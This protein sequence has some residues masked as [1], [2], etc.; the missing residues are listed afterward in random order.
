MSQIARNLPLVVFLAILALR[1]WDPLVA[2][3]MRLVVFDTYQRIKPRAY[4]PK[5]PVKIVDV[6]KVSRTRFGPWPWPR[7]VIA[8]LVA[9]LSKAGAAAIVFDI[10][11]SDPDRTSPEEAVRYWPDTDAVRSFRNS[12]AGL[13]SHD[14]KLA[15][16]M[17]GTPV[18]TGFLLTQD[19]AAPAGVPADKA[20]F[21]FGG[22]DPRTF[23]PRYRNAIVNLPIIAAAS[24]GNGALNSIYDLDRV[25]RR[26]PLVLRLNDKLYPSI[27]AETL[28]VAQRARN[29]VIKASGASGVES[30]GEPTGLET[31]RIGHYRIPT[32]SL[33]RVW[34][35]FTKH[36][37]ERFIPAWKVLADDFDP[38]LVAG[39]IVFIWSSAPGLFDLRSTPIEPAIPNV[40]IKAQVI[41]QIIAGDYLHRPGWADA[42][43]L[44]SMFLIGLLLIVLLRHLGALTSLVVGLGGI[45]FVLGGSWIAFDRYSWLLDP[46]L[47]TVMV[48]FV[49]MTALAVSYIRSETERIRA[50]ASEH[51]HRRQTQLVNLLRRSAASANQ[52]EQ[53]EDALQGCLD[54][55][56]T[57]TAWPVGHVYEV[58]A[59]SA[60]VLLPTGIWHLDDPPRFAA[61]RALT[62]RT[63]VKRGIDLPGRVLQ[64]G[65]P[66]W[67]ADLGSHAN[68]PRAGPAEDAGIRAALGVPV[69]AGSEIAAVLEFFA[70][71]AAEPDAS[72]LSAIDNIGTQVGR[73]I[74]RKRAQDLIVR[75][76]AMITESIGYASNIQRSALPDKQLLAEALG[77]TFVIWE[78]RDV[79]GGDIYWARRIEDG[80][81]VAVADC[82]GHGV[83]GAFMTMI[84][85]GALMQA[86][87]EYPDGDPAKIIA[88]MHGF[89][90]NSLRQGD[91]AGDSDDG[92]D[93]GICRIDADATSMTYAGA[94]FP[95]LMI[96][97]GTAQE[98]KGDRF[99]I[100]YRQTEPAPRFTNHR[101]DLV[102]GMAFYLL[103]DGFVDQVGG[104]RRRAFGRRR[105]LRHL[106]DLQGWSLEE[107]RRSLLAAL[108]D[109]QGDEVRRD[110]VTVLAFKPRG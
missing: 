76:H 29:I 45:A 75:A 30:F 57:Y 7:S 81:L 2:Q 21:A 12:L 79:V 38:A 10:V 4:D 39:Q 105:L 35:R 18:V 13:P 60:D 94:R 109:Y 27:L 16:A 90:Q 5:S 51:A 59:K 72:L 46:I 1:V 106:L 11:F 107:Q 68:L 49:F 110:D 87:N 43:E 36:A 31:V 103:T 64:T 77:E 104:D 88:R 62:E 73:A 47:P 82:T 85:T 91:K 14:Q 61:L 86:L 3:H 25:T 65:E 101:I 67:L 80:Y 33:G 83:P 6:E 100:G 32:D 69:R 20:A 24:A 44:T 93:L 84:A 108:D 42:V 97:D 52:A 17:R 74:E 54:A 92:L 9:R 55:I 66:V 78:P 8:D 70:A 15:A 63:P 26:L 50:S 96:A 37:P 40:E 95:L 99:A 41:E 23:V 28:R 98:I 19:T 56:C 71:E 34:G 58:S 22:D 89:V 53:V 102:P 48:V